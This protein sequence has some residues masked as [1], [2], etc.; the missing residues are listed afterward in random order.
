VQHGFER[1]VREHRSGRRR[2][3]DGDRHQHKIN[4]RG[5]VRR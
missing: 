2:C 1:H 4:D 3:N 5:R